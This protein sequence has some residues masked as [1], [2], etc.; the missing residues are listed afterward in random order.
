MCIVFAVRYLLIGNYGAGNL[1]DEA[2]KE[3]FLSAFPEMEWRV[4]SACPG[5]GELPRLPFGL[6][7]L[8]RPWWKTLAAF[9][10][11]DGVV[12]GGGTLFTDVESVRACLLWWWHALWAC[13]LGKKI[14]MASQGI[15]PFRTRMGMWCARWTCARAV[16][17]SVR[18]AESLQ[19]VEGWR[20]S[21]KVI[22]TCDPVYLLLQSAKEA[23]RTQ[24]VLCIIPRRNSSDSFQKCVL[25]RARDRSWQAITILSFQP[26]DPEEQTVTQ[27]IASAVGG[28][29][30]PIRALGDAV[31]FISGASFVLTQ[32]YHGAIVAQALG[33]PFEAAAQEEGDKLAALIPENAQECSV[34]AQAGEEALRL[35][36]AGKS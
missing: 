20:L 18:D 1:G 16:F 22:Q 3:Y 2:L 17:V 24:N 25:E 9:R 36:L 7:S 6:R 30:I 21:K 23:V 12:F 5:A 29:V 34:R 27:E 4:I 28:S 10:S 13:L 32:R 15:G 11:C 31:R 14:L 35:A 19:R 33:I 8:L 26:D